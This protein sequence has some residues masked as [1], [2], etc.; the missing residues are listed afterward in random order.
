MDRVLGSE[1][2]SHHLIKDVSTLFSC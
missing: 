1:E 2:G